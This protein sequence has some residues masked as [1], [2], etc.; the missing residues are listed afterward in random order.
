MTSQGAQEARVGQPAA[1]WLPLFGTANLLQERLEG[2]KSALSRK[3]LIGKF[4]TPH[5]GRTVAIDVEGRQGRATLQC[6]EGRSKRKDY[7]F[8]IEWDDQA[9]RGNEPTAQLRD[10]SRA[11]TTP[12]RTEHPYKSTCRPVKKIE[13]EAE[14]TCSAQRPCTA[15]TGSAENKEGW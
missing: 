2:A 10:R 3:T 1:D 12:Q 8:D 5:V 15:T 14:N 4:L 6:R 9:P 7:Y 13:K 11:A